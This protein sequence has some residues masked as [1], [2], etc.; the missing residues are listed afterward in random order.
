M[1]PSRNTWISYFILFRYLWIFCKKENAGSYDRNIVV[2]I[3]YVIYFDGI[4]V[5]HT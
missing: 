2:P 1:L 4:L 5:M 3:D